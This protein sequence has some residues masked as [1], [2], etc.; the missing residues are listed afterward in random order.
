MKIHNN[1]ELGSILLVG[2]PAE[3]T[4]NEQAPLVTAHSNV[5][6]GS[7][8]NLRFAYKRKEK[9]Q[10]LHSNSRAGQGTA[11]SNIRSIRVGDQTY[12]HRSCHDPKQRRPIQFLLGA[13]R[14]SMW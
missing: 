6:D 8:D 13:F 12:G 2:N 9:S 10:Y 14:K 5:Q 3:T 1:H 7:V 4:E 11:N